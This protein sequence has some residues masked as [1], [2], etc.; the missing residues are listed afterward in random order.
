[1]TLLWIPL[2]PLFGTLVPL[3]ADRFGRRVTLAA[4][5]F[6][7]ALALVCL[8]SLMPQVLAGEVIHW[9]TAWLANAGL[10]LAFHL[11]GL[12]LLFSI[13]ILG[14]GL[15]VLLYARYYLSDDDHMGRFYAFLLLFMSAM[16]GVV[17][18]DNLL[19]LWAYWELTS[20]SSFLLISFWWHKTEARKGARMALTITGAGGLALL[21][22]FILIGALLLKNIVQDYFI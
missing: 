4:T 22:A 2:L 1:M 5:A 6:I 13:L 8:L 10:S 9:Q 21:A 16:L 18:S 3:L 12:G 7:P 20:I 11:D 14:I 19:Q 15:L 17:L